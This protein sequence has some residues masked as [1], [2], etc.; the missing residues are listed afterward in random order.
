VIS[1]G[2]AII[3]GTLSASTLL[4]SLNTLATF[5]A[6]PVIGEVT[7]LFAAIVLLRIL[8]QG[9]TGKFFRRAL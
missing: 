2:A 7:L 3:T 8:P 5:I 9:I 6:T 1:G 4:G